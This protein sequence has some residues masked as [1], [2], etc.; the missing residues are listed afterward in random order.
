MCLVCTN[1]EVL[2]CF[3]LHWEC[4]SWAVRLAYD[5]SDQ[6]HLSIKCC[7]CINEMNVNFQLCQRS[8]QDYHWPRLSISAHRVGLH[9][10]KRL[11]VGL[12]QVMSAV[13][14]ALKARLL[15][16]GVF[17]AKLW[18]DHPRYWGGTVRE[19]KRLEYRPTRVQDGVGWQGEEQERKKCRLRKSH[20]PKVETECKKSS[21]G[22]E[23]INIAPQNL[24]HTRNASDITWCC[25]TS[26]QCPTGWATC[27]SP[28]SCN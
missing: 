23:R 6:V 11:L 1:C 4:R 28:T 20:Q 22:K 18:R 3:A 8:V 21:G 16:D 2:L 14:L 7:G 10:D 19:D 26:V 15:P 25:F 27:F 24:P 13:H 5:L 12:V 17:W 9:G